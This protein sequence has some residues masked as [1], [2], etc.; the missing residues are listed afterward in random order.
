MLVPKEHSD[1][2]KCLAL[3]TTMEVE[4]AKI[5]TEQEFQKYIKKYWKRQYSERD[6]DQI[7]SCKLLLHENHLQIKKSTECRG[8]RECK[9]G[10]NQG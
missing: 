1:D 10:K 6:G 7:R 9:T 4:R 5:N 3:Q 8:I 2:F